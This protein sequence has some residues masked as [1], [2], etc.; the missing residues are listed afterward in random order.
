MI[1][2]VVFVI[3][4]FFYVIVN[5]CV[6]YGV[7]LVGGKFVY[8]YC[9]DLGEVLS[10]IEWEKIIGLIGVLVM[11]CEVINYFDFEK[12]DILSL[13]MLGGGGV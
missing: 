1:V 6:V 11:V 3:M 10:L 13:L 5:N 9:W 12:I 8:M 2:F 4:F 7:M